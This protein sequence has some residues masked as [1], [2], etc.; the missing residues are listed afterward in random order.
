M[1]SS[2]D[3][4]EGSDSSGDDQE[5]GNRASGKDFPLSHRCLSPKDFRLN[6]IAESLLNR[7]RELTLL[8]QDP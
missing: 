7:P 8:V 5:E 1:D 6:D 3:D 4:D 2:D